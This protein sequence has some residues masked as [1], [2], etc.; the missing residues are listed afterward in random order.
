MK[1]QIKHNR[2][3]YIYFSFQQIVLTTFTT[4]KKGNIFHDLL[5]CYIIRKVYD[6]LLQRFFSQENGSIFIRTNNQTRMSVVILLRQLR[7][8]I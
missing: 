5:T 7:G 3:V 2:F 6:Y 8:G 4:I 1:C